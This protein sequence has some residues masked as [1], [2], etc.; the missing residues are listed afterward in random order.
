MA[1]D[2]VKTA[3]QPE[4]PSN[5]RIADEL[6]IRKRIK[7]TG[8][9]VKGI[10]QSE[11]KAASAVMKKWDRKPEDGWDE[12]IVVKNFDNVPHAVNQKSVKSIQ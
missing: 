7:R 6:F 2:T 8:G 11:Q 1:N 3:P 9:F 4:P 10:D 12:S 5:D